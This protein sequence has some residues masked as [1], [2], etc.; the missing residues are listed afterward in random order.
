MLGPRHG[1]Q[2]YKVPKASLTQIS[3]YF[4]E[5]VG[6]GEVV[7]DWVDFSSFRIFLVW[8]GLGNMK[9]AEGFINVWIVFPSPPFQLNSPTTCNLQSHALPIPLSEYF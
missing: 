3:T 5:R 2:E 7:L 9:R 1:C 6:L 8:V 4:A